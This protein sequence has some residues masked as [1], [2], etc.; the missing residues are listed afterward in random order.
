MSSGLVFHGVLPEGISTNVWRWGVHDRDSTRMCEAVLKRGQTF[1]DVGAHFGYFSLLASNLVGSSGEVIAIEALPET[2][3]YLQ[4]NLAG[5]PATVRMVQA[6]AWDSPGEVLFRDGGIVNSSLSGAFGR[7]QKNLMAQREVS[8]AVSGM[9]LDDLLQDTAD[10]GL[11]KIDVESSEMRVLLGARRFLARCRPP[12]LIELSDA[13]FSGEA[14]VAPS[15]EIVKFL[16]AMGYS[17]FRF[18]SGMFRSIVLTA[19]VPYLNAMFFHREKIDPN[20]V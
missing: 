15:L 12:L 17:P 16:D 18:V 9:P 7:L 4:R 1:V 19:P 6:A 3:G 20:L 5:V 2:F 13:G 11:V 14:N 8:V 10:V